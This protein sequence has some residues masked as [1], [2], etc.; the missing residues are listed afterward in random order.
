MP[1]L[2]VPPGWTVGPGGTLVPP[3]FGTG[4][5]SGI[6]GY[7]NN[8]G[9]GGGSASQYAP[10]PPDLAPP[11]ATLNSTG[12]D[13]MSPPRSNVGTGKEV[14]RWTNPFTE[15]HI[16][17]QTG[18]PEY[19]GGPGATIGLGSPAARYIPKWLGNRLAIA[20]ATAPAVMEGLTNWAHSGNVPS[21]AA[22]GGDTGGV[23]IADQTALTA[24][25]PAPFVQPHR[26]VSHPYPLPFESGFPT[27]S[28]AAAPRMPPRTA[29]PA[30][31]YA[32]PGTTPGPVNG[33]INPAS[34]N[35][36]RSPFT[37]IYRPNA[38]PLHPGMGGPPKTTALDLSHLFG[39]GQ[40]AAAASKPPPKR[41]A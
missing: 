30:S 7:S 6:T 4:D 11:G 2:P 5:P 13:I 41:V 38:D 25:A 1:P 8:V 27:A 37:T 15:A 12:P 14:G 28:P 16:N 20:S 17:P 3:G 35:L 19:V 34:I 31:A 18:Q 32:T 39:G 24:P 26:P 21:S 22:F 10:P 29:T 9:F 33:K 23:P 36:G 40:P